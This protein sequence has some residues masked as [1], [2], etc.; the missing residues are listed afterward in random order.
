MEHILFAWLGYSDL[1]ACQDDSG[2]TLGPVTEAVMMRSNTKLFLL[3]NHSEE[4]SRAYTSWLSKRTA[5]ETKVK[6]VDLDDPMDFNRI[7][8]YAK[9]AVT[10]A[11]GLWGDRAHIVLDL[12]PGTPAMAAVW[13]ILAKTCYP[14][15]ELIV[16]G[17]KNEVTGRY[18]IRTVS[19][20]FDIAVDPIAD[21]LGKRDDYLV[22]LVQGLPDEAPKF[23]RIV[24]KCAAMKHVIALARTVAWHNVPV[25]LLGESGTGKELI[26]GAIH[27]TSQREDRPFFPVNCGAITPT[28]IESELFGH[29]EG[30]FTGATSKRKGLFDQAD[31]GTLFLDEI[32]DFGLDLQV[33]LLRVLQEGTIQPVGA[34]SPHYVDVRIIAATNR[35]LVEQVAEG[36]FRGDLFYRLAV[37]VIP[38]PPLRERQG[39]VSLLAD[40]FL[41]KINEQLPDPRGFKTK[42]INAGAR[43]AILRHDWPG[44]VR[45]LENTLTRAAIWSVGS[46]IDKQDIEQAIIHIRPPGADGILDRPLGQDLN[47][48]ELLAQVAAHYVQRALKESG[49]NKSRAAKLVGLSNHETFGN[50]MRKYGVKDI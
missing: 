7:Y 14:Q 1:N 8:G 42:R 33:K 21:I 16:S 37:G 28:L 19:V 2:H 27:R 30:A 45:E 40:A 46:S 22:R 25:L 24:H 3:S 43:A 4:T 49:G 50:W 44:N 26:A 18:G 32:G 29:I 41:K 20:P 11:L 35:N 17:P 9:D 47:I 39:D 34:T 5:V 6:L 12:S 15:A 36:K 13:I 23:D 31:G 10:E 48:K 38:I